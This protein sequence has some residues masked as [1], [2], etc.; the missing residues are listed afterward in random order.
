M[1]E[2]T[3]FYL[4]EHTDNYSIGQIAAIFH[5][6]SQDKSINLQVDLVEKDNV[7]LQ[8]HHRQSEVEPNLL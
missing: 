3:E 7:L 5:H 4:S 1:D 6:W 8:I 2:F